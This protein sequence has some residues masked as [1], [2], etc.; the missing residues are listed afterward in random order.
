M[1]KK[2]RRFS[3]RQKQA[4]KGAALGVVG[5]ST[6]VTAAA[7]APPLVIPALLGV[8]RLGEKIFEKRKQKR[9]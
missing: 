5:I 3:E 7:V 4:M 9:R 1:V 2:K 8:E 6:I